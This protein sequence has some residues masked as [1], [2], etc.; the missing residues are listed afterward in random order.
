MKRER[1]GDLRERQP[2]GHG[3][4]AHPPHLK[5]LA[6]AISGEVP[7]L[8]HEVT[9]EELRPV[10]REAIT[11][12][13]LRSIH[14][15]V[16]LVPDALSAIQQDLASDNES[17]RHRAAALLL[18]YTLGHPAMV[19]PEEADNSKQIIVNF[20]GMSRP[21]IVEAELAEEVPPEVESGDTKEC[22][23]CHATKPLGEFVESSDRC[24]ACF[25]EQQRQQQELL[26]AT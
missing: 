2:H 10:V 20:G 18:K 17:I 11:E 1:E 23:K 9:S 26:D 3:N 14:T 6:D 25:D 13:V 19:P 5:R 7:D 15:A 8:I 24:R 12:D 22:D 16:G 4:A 21:E